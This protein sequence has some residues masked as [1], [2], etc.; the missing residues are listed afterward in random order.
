[1]N[2][3]TYNLTLNPKMDVPLKGVHDMFDEAELGM[4]QVDD[5]GIVDA[6]ID[7]ARIKPRTL[8]L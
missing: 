2:L 3:V 6:G 4:R 7:A 8:T 1:M 5:F